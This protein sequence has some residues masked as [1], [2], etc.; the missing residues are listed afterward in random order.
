MIKVKICGITSRKDAFAAV[1]AGADA[2]GFVMYRASPRAVT[3]SLAREIAASLPAGPVRV[4]VFVESPGSAI[5]EIA[6]YCGFNLVQ[7]G[8]GGPDRAE[9]VTGVP[10]MAAFRIGCRLDATRAAGERPALFLFDSRVEGRPG[11]TGRTFDWSLLAG[12]KFPAPFF[13][14]GG[15]TRANVG[16][17]IRKARPFGVDVSTGVERSPGTKDAALLRAFVREARAV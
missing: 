6:D 17:A 5:A 2:I 4:G 12:L 10:V 1:D 3:P 16:A 11:G 14:A 9:R 13:L 8:G 7:F 15:L